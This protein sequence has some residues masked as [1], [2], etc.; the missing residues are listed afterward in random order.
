MGL[1]TYPVVLELPVAMLL[2][3]SSWPILVSKLHDYYT[4]L[5]QPWDLRS[6]SVDPLCAIDLGAQ[7][8]ALAADPSSDLVA[9]GTAKGFVVLR[10]RPRDSGE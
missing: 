2:A 1:R 6:G 10:F 7:V 4:G 3:K 5:V 8:T 9:I